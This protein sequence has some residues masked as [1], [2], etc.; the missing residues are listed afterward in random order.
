MANFI[1]GT[2]GSLLAVT[3][4]TIIANQLHQNF[5]QHQFTLKTIKTQGDLIVDKPLWQIDG[6]D[7][8]TKELDK[9]LTDKIVDF[10]V[11]SYKDL[12]VDR[13]DG[14]AL[15]A[16]T[17]RIF[18]HDVLLI[19]KDTL[20]KI[21]NK[22]LTKLRIG[23]SSPRRQYLLKNTIKDYLPF[24]KTLDIE[25]LDLR[26]NVNSRIEKLRSNEYDLICLALA[27]LDR[28]SALDTS[29][30]KLETLLSNIELKLLP[31][32]VFPAAPAQGALAIECLTENIAISNILKTLH[33]LKTATE[34]EQEKKIFKS[35]GGGCH[36]SLG[37]HAYSFDSRNISI[38]A[39]GFVDE[40]P[41]TI[42]KIIPEI[43]ITNVKSV[44][45]I[46][47]GLTHDRVKEL[48][49]NSRFIWDQSKTIVPLKTPSPSDK[50]QNNYIISSEHCLQTFLEQVPIINNSFIWASGASVHQKLSALGYWVNGDNDSQGNTILNDLKNSRL[51][52]FMIKNAPLI[53]LSHQGN[54]NSENTLWPTFL[55]THS[56]DTCTKEFIQQLEICKIFF[57]TSYRQ[58]SF[59]NQTFAFIH[60][61][62]NYHYCGY[63]KTFQQFKE[64]NVLTITPLP[65]INY[66]VKHILNQHD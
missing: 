42:N 23:T 30:E 55:S 64:N 4:S 32:S 60:N 29:F 10:V 65:N 19:T 17:K 9:A 59:F 22:S 11:H 52:D 41:I 20:T 57:W 49:L 38:T 45:P 21:Q 62:D 53:H 5:P 25:Y 44:A 61:K 58:Y 18:A 27:G 34:V 24:G 13:P 47:L 2:R 36:L 6:K 3:Q 66:F 63:G 35:F 8:F 28:L 54:K 50:D 51:H 16:I 40:N 37:V 39:S 33:C 26:G 56:T 7:F 15:A 48:N 46:F 12:S 43:K 31:L 1:L 14:I